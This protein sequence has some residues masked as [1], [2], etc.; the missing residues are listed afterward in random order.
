MQG[1][2]PAAIPAH[3]Q[4]ADAAAVCG[5]LWLRLYGYGCGGGGTWLWLRLRRRQL[6]GCS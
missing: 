6:H 2:V 5:R 1:R 4:P 3:D